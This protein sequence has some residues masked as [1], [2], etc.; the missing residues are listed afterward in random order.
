MSVKTKLITLLISILLILPVFFNSTKTGTVLGIQDT[1]NEGGLELQ[2]GTENVGYIAGGVMDNKIETANSETQI[3]KGKAILNLNADT[4][5]T[6]KNFSLAQEISVGYQG[7][8]YDLI[9]S[10]V[11]KTLPQDV[12]LVLDRET[13]KLIAGDSSAENQEIEVIVNVN[14]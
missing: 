7:N 10:K 13:F 4:S 9:V 8:S 3:I 5:V 14:K 11:D 1:R 2:N 6:A 12:V